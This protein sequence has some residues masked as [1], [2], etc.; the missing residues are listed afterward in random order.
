MPTKSQIG[1]AAIK[2]NRITAFAI[3]QDDV[4]AVIRLC[5]E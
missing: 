5:R 1:I 4:A 2:V 3:T